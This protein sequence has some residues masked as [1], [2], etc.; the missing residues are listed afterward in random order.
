MSLRRTQLQQSQKSRDLKSLRACAEDGADVINAQPTAQFNVQ[1]S[2][3]QPRFKLLRKWDVECIQSTID[4][5]DSVVG[6][7]GAFSVAASVSVAQ[8]T[9]R[10]DGAKV[11]ALL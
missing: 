8:K 6:S 3:A 4:D 5:N 9:I 1:R 7:S 2:D 10:V 11:H